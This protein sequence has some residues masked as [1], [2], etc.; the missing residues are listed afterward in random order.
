ML[1]FQNGLKENRMNRDFFEQMNRALDV[2]EKNRDGKA[3][4]YAERKILFQRNVHAVSQE[5]V[6]GGCG[7]FSENIIETCTFWCSRRGVSERSYDRRWCDSIAAR[8]CESHD[9]YSE[10]IFLDQRRRWVYPQL[11]SLHLLSEQRFLHMYKTVYSCRV[12]VT[13]HKRH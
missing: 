2:V 9:E 13:L 5:L 4:G 3:A 7:Y 12:V 8:R 1:R 11:I 6:R 10:T